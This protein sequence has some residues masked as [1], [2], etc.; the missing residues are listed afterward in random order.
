MQKNFGVKYKIRIGIYNEQG[1]IEI[2]I[3]MKKNLIKL[4]G[5][6]FVGFLIIVTACGTGSSKTDSAAKKTSVEVEKGEVSKQLPNY[7]YVDLDTILSK[8]NLAKD[9]NEEML[10]MQTNFENVGRQKES[11][12]QNLV[13]TIQKKQQN[14]SYLSEASYMD[15]MQKLENMQVSAQKELEKMQV[16]MQN[17]AFE[18]QKIV[19]DSIESFVKE[20]NKSRKYD[21]ILFKAAT[22]YIDPSLDI[23]EEV[24]IGLNARYNNVAK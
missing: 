21:A 16:N 1:K 13:A 10:R 7:R 19:N 6:S 3:K 4:L 11:S 24:V 9:Y 18:A 2:I 8:Y 17:A 23:T 22:L 5:I 12:I 15:D 20:F 14:N